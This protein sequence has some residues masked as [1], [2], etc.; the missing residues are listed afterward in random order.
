MK[1]TITFGGLC[2]YL[3]CWHAILCLENILNDYH[4][5]FYFFIFLNVP[6]A[7]SK[8]RACFKPLQLAATSCVRLV[9]TQELLVF[10]HTLLDSSKTSSYLS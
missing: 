9:C 3:L 1:V 5:C 8:M 7:M 10:G 6:C 4:I 2:S